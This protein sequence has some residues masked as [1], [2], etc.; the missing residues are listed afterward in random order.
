MNERFQPDGLVRVVKWLIVVILVFGLAGC[1]FRSP[2][3]RAIESGDLERVQ[4]LIEA[5]PDQLHQV[6]NP[7][8]EV[9]LVIA[10]RSSS[11]EV[12][13][14]L[15]EADQDP[16]VMSWVGVSRR[17]IENA[18][19]YGNL[20]ILKLLVEYGG[21]VEPDSEAERSL[22]HHAARVR[23]TPELINYLIEQG[24]GVD[25]QS[26]SAGYMP[27][28]YAAWSDRPEIITTL[29]EAGADPGAVSDNGWTP[30]RFAIFNCS[31][32]LWDILIDSGADP[33]EVRP[34]TAQTL[35]AREYM[36]VAEDCGRRL[37]VE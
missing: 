4:S 37:V 28:H 32:E 16:V 30:L 5:D 19:A 2:L 36:E 14:F 17:A 6:Q 13:R 20:E 26:R 23:G 34:N 12:V 27:L 8:G 35:S 9:P 22:L 1:L 15:L 11:P 21:S 3:V 24:H 33:D 29:I 31:Q 18:V 7:L 25:D 10:A